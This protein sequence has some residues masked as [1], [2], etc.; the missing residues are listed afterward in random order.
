MNPKQASYCT[1]RNSCAKLSS[2]SMIQKAVLHLRS[3]EQ[4]MHF[5]AYLGTATKSA[6]GHSC[7]QQRSLGR[8][9]CEQSGAR[10]RWG[11]AADRNV[12]APAEVRRCAWYRISS[13]F[14]LAGLLF[15]QSHWGAAATAE[16][17]LSALHGA[18]AQ[19][20]SN[21]VTLSQ[22]RGSRGH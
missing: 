20:R 5:R 22:I 6:R 10:C 15:S 2:A 17:Y 9:A 16:N 7:P 21:L 8:L 14:L 19:T 12:R 4:R 3:V 18:I 11:L 13:A 1:N